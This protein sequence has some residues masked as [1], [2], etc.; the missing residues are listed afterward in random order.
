MTEEELRKLV[1]DASSALVK[2]RDQGELAHAQCYRTI[3][4][5]ANYLIYLIKRAEAK[6]A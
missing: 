1:V 2:A 4:H 3:V 5:N 6:K